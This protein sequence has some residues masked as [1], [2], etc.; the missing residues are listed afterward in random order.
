MLRYFYS[1]SI[2]NFLLETEESILGK[3]AYNNDFSLE[4]TQKS[5]WLKE[6]EILKHILFKYPGTIFFEYSIPRMGR[7][8][9]VV[10]IIRSV[11]FVLE[12]KVG[13]K[14]FTANAVDQVWDYA[15]D[16]KNFHETSHDHLIAP[17]LIATEAKYSE[18]YTLIEKSYQDLTLSPIKTNTQN[19]QSVIEG[20]LTFS[21]EN[22]VIDGTNWSKGRYAPTPNILEAA[23]ALYNNHSV[24][25]ISRSDASAKN[26]SDTSSAI[27]KIIVET[28]NKHAKSI[29]FVTGVPGAGKTLVGLDIATKFLKSESE[30]TS[31]FLSGNG[32]LVAILREALTR[33]RWKREKA[34]GRKTKKG[35]IF[36]EVKAFVQNVHNF[37]DECLIDMERPPF[38]HIAIFDE[39]QRAW[40]LLQTKNFMSRK[41]NHKDFAYSEPEYLISCLDRH[42]DWAVIVCLVGGGQEINT[43]EAGIAEWIEGLNRS[44]LDWN[45]HVSSKL[46][47]SEYAAGEALQLIKNKDRLFTNNDLHLS[48]SMRSFRAE[49][50]SLFVKLLLDLDIESANQVY[51]EIKEKYPIVLT[52]D[53]PKAKEWLKTKARG[54]ERYGIVVSSQ[55]Q[56]LKPY[57]IDVKSPID[58]IHWFLDEKDDIR[59]SFYLEDV[60]TEFQVQG[61]E[62]DWACIT[63]DGDLRYSPDGW[64]HYSFSGNKWQNIRKEERKMYQKNAYRVLLTRARQGMIIVV[65][66]GDPED[67]T[68]KAEYY[69]STYDYLKRVGIIEL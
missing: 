52:R 13:E 64:Q 41:K 39:A 2:Q 63:W 46:T 51:N 32:P 58:P 5:A 61:L 17:V 14:E 49:K 1:N 26:L 15:L 25:D 20:V 27:E 4:L 47:D 59:S 22:T 31:V 30:T 3:L 8:I 23:M 54:S 21:D 18:Q 48:V 56:R 29:C 10:L 6:I 28:K 53:L 36:S 9:D 37:R 45:I 69:N 38:D 7:R 11:I 43:G 19:L 66:K 44:F 35:Q 65:P 40:D 55:A 50:V 16:L 34:N 42:K 60:A 33:D 57:A 12:F 67:K 24:A 68:R 62:L